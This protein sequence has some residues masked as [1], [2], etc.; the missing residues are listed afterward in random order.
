MLNSAILSIASFFASCTQSEKL[1][2]PVCTVE[3]AKTIIRGKFWQVADVITISG[4]QQSLSNNDPSKK[5]TIAKPAT[6][7]F[8]WLTTKKEKVSH[9]AFMNSFYK[10]NLKI[11]TTLNKNCIAT[12]TTAMDA[13]NKYFNKSQS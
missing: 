2:P 1:P 7:A 6:K 5:E 13:Q 9:A 12:T 11:S 8:N 10:D 3:Q 4:N